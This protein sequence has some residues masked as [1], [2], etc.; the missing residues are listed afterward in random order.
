MIKNKF[1]NWKQNIEGIK[2]FELYL[3]LL[4]KIT[5][6][7]KLN[8]KILLKQSKTQK[9]PWAG[10]PVRPKDNFWTIRSKKLAPRG[11]KIN[12]GKQEMR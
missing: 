9:W 6:K 10:D 11:K 5:K 3:E 2:E 4:G 12:Q 7:A 8:F 1:L